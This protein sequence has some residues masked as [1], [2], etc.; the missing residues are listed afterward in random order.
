MSPGQLFMFS[1][2]CDILALSTA[3]RMGRT[4][5]VSYW[6]EKSRLCCWYCHS[7]QHPKWAGETK[8]RLSLGSTENRAWIL[9]TRPTLKGRVVRQG[10][11]MK[12]EV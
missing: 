2:S 6:V 1:K 3:M 8:R 4:G 9:K 12:G 10:E 11:F 7:H 5:Q